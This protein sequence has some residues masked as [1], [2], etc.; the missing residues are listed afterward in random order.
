MTYFTTPK[1]ETKPHPED[2][3][4]RECHICKKRVPLDG[5]GALSRHE[6]IKDIK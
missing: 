3:G 1:L 5:M 6:C 4:L 2:D